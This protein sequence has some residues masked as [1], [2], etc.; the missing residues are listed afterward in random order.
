MSD[1][2]R[3][4]SFVEKGSERECWA[5]LGCK[6]HNGYGQVRFDGRARRA[7]RISWVLA[8]GRSTT[9]LILHSCDNP[10]CVNPSHLRE[11]SA[12]ENT[13]DMMERGRQRFSNTT[14]CKNGHDVVAEGS[15]RL[16]KFSQGRVAKICKRC[17]LERT[18]RY[19]ARLKQERQKRSIGAAQ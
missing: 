8:N 15:T 14:H 4:W 6:T 11:G 7:H 18:Q 19:R 9:L 17:E 16:A 1:T 3:F 2:E 12:A 13:A 5:W 10:S